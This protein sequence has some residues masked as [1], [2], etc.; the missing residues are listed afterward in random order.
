MNFGVYYF[1]NQKMY[2]VFWVEG[3]L[4]PG[5]PKLQVVEGTAH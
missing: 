2:F 3:M 4:F 1:F 5:T